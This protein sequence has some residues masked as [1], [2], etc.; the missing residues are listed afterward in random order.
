MATNVCNPNERNSARLAE[1]EEVFGSK[2]EAF[3]ALRDELQGKREISIKTAE[4]V[5]RLELEAD[6]YARAN[7]S[8]AEEFEQARQ[9]F[10]YHQILP[11]DRR[12]VKSVDVATLTDAVFRR[13]TAPLVDFLNKTRRGFINN[14]KNSK[15]IHNFFREAD[16]IDT[17][18]ATAKELL[19]RYK[20][21]DDGIFDELNSLGANRSRLSD[22]IYVPQDLDR[23]QMLKAGREQWVDDI[24]AE[25]DVK[26]SFPGKGPDEVRGIL[27][28]IYD[29]R[30]GILPEKL[31]GPDAQFRRKA[32]AKRRDDHHRVLHYKTYE[33][34]WRIN[35][36][37]SAFQGDFVSQLVSM[38]QQRS[39]EVALITKFGPDPE[40]A[41]GQLTAN[42]SIEPQFSRG[43]THP[44]TETAWD[45]VSGKVDYVAQENV[46][47]AQKSQAVRDVILSAKLGGA[48]LTA[49]PT[50]TITSALRSA[51]NGTGAFGPLRRLITGGVTKEQAA[52][53]GH[54]LSII[55]D[56]VAGSNRYGDI[57]DIG[58]VTGK[59]A[60]AVLKGQGL[61][62]WT[63]A[64]KRAFIQNFN[65]KFA[66]A[67]GKTW[68]ELPVA[69]RDTISQSG[70]TAS[71]WDVIRANGVEAFDGVNYI[72]ADRLSPELQ[73]KWL[74]AS[75]REANI[76]IPTA[77]AKQRAFATGGKQK[78]TAIGEVARFGTQFTST[79]IRIF[80]SF[81]GYMQS[82]KTFFNK[83]SYA[84][85][86][87]LGS[88][89]AGYTTLQLKQ[90]AS[91]KEPFD[92]TNLDAD[93]LRNLGIDS[94]IQGSGFGFFADV[95]FS[96]A[97]QD[98]YGKSLKD[99]ILPP[100][101]QE[102]SKLV[103]TLTNVDDDTTVG[104]Y[105]N[106]LAQFGLKNVPGANMWQLRLLVERYISNQLSEV[107]DPEWNKKVRKLKKKLDKEY[108]TDYFWAP[109]ELTP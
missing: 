65:Y 24:L 61:L 35:Q 11:D 29:A 58:S 18:D 23:A 56:A 28:S 32:L 20:A 10:F 81:L 78:G 102:T 60:N 68:D 12:K 97:L 89:V 44:K 3:R 8:N 107:L 48:T 39:R 22:D 25:L 67:A 74:A 7:S 27:N 71:D 73:Y 96:A 94:I 54:E 84:A 33:G 98:G 50:D 4:Q 17:G 100:V 64:S 1:L 40:R 13:H 101:V 87:L 47:L 31:D 2:Q 72:V 37:Y 90:I 63:D 75:T 43:I 19:A 30:V 99:S 42:G 105:T 83:A 52:R 80:D 106:E 36:K 91:G 85:F 79:P 21:M 93:Q 9:E 62:T 6:E 51:F 53:M 103:E 70:I 26:R 77:G 92:I 16:G 66:Q 46:G 49:V 95:V 69:Q 45:V 109:G 55:T 5:R 86:T 41:F 76:A 82:D 57:G 38:T 108:S 15:I 59:I 34:Q 104:S 14:S 88:A